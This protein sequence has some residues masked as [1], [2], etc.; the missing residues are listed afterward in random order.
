MNKGADDVQN[1]IN[2]AEDVTLEP[3]RPLTRTPAPG[4]PY[5][6]D[7]LGE[8]LGNAARAIHDRVKLPLA[9][10]A[11]SVMAS[12]AL[13]VQPHANI[14]LPIG[15]RHIRPPSLDFVCIATIGERKTSSDS[16]ASWPLCKRE[17]ALRKIHDDAMLTYLN[18]REGWEHARST[19]KRNAKGDAAAIAAALAKVGPPPPR[20]LEPML[21]LEEPSFEGLCKLFAIGQPSLGL[22]TTEGGAFLGG[23]AMQPETILRTATGL[24]QLW[25]GAPLRRVRAGEGA[26]M[27][28]GRRLSVHLMLQ[29]AIAPMLFSHKVLRG[30]G[31]LSRF[32]TVA[33]TTAIGTRFQR[34]PD[35]ETEPRLR[36]Y[37]ARLLDILEAPL[38]LEPG[39]LNELAPPVMELSPSAV[40]LWGKFADHVERESAAGKSLESVQALASKAA[41]HAVRLAAVLTLVDNIEGREIGTERL[42]AGITLTEFY[43]DEALRLEERGESDG[44]DALQRANLLLGWLQL[45][46]A[47]IDED[48]IALVDCYQRGPTCIRNQQ[49]AREAITILENHGW[50]IRIAGGAK[51]N[52]A[53]RR[54]VWR[55]WK[56]RQGA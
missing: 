6:V 32:L 33:P 38:P 46:P 13:S 1:G 39:T 29:P 41:E 5:P 15:E 19:I 7:A 35:P 28:V 52:G 9:I 56:D 53:T 44:D 3:P 16:E 12:A 24:S 47:V 30:Q 25:D 43:L 45:G 31:L 34:P 8:L 23:Y 36:K 54:D 17:T 4:K 21:L 42:R 37:F 27:L 49:A 11:Q 14:R 40:A 51:V 48:R 20:P 2:D 55:V 50:L 10:P 22:F 26:S 18:A